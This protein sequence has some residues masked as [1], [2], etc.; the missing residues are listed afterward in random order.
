MSEYFETVGVFPP[1]VNEAGLVNAGNSQFCNGYTDYSNTGSFRIDVDETAVAV[2]GGST[3]APQMTGT[4]N[5]SGGVDW[6]CSR[7][8]TAADQLKYLPSTCRGT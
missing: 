8:G 1:G 6:R 5:V 2:P 4:G 7:G 3:L